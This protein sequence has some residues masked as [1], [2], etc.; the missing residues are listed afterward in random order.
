MDDSQ[1][2]GSILT[3]DQCIEIAK[4]YAMLAQAEA[5]DKMTQAIWGLGDPIERAGRNG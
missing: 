3:Q 2:S 4:V 5:Q 1:R